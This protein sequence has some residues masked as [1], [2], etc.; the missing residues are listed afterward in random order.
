MDVGVQ[1]TSPRARSS[2]RISS[3]RRS[4]GGTSRPVGSSH[5]VDVMERIKSRTRT[6]GSRKGGVIQS[7]VGP[8]VCRLSRGAATTDTGLPLSLE[9]DPVVSLRLQLASSTSPS[10]VS[11]NVIAPD[12]SAI[13]AGGGVPS[14]IS[15]RPLPVHRPPADDSQDQRR[16]RSIHSALVPPVERHFPGAHSRGVSTGSRATARS[17]AVR[18]P[19]ALRATSLEGEFARVAALSR[20]ASLHPAPAARRI[21]SASPPCAPATARPAPSRSRPRGTRSRR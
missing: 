21:P 19:V 14:S 12:V 4:S 17:P 3:A 18:S 2:R 8:A 11:R 13:R 5:W 10:R 20:P 15:P 9:D 1:S 16:P 7:L 6:Q